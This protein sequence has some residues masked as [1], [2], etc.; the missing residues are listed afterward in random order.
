MPYEIKNVFFTDFPVFVNTECADRKNSR[1][2]KML[3]RIFKNPC[4]TRI[5]IRVTISEYDVTSKYIFK[6]TTPYNV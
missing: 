4:Q 2:T 6:E 3:Q 1:M 5:K